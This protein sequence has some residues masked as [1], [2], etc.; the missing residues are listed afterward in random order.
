VTTPKNIAASVRQKLLN[1][2]KKDRRPFNE[3]L[4]YY[5]MERFLYR[6]SQSE[7]AKRFILKGGLMLR[8]W[9][10]PEI[11]P[12]MDI[13]MLAKTSNDAGKLKAQVE[14]MLSVDVEPD[15][16]IFSQESIQT[17]L[18]AE[19]ANYQ[20]VRIRFRGNLGSARINVQLDIGFSDVV[21][22]PPIE[23][24]V[25]TMLDFAAPVLL[26]YCRESS[27]AE[28]FEAMVK[29]GIVNSR[30]KDFYDIWLLS[31]Q[32]DFNGSVLSRA[33]EL[34]FENRRTDL[35]ENIEAFQDAFISE[36][37]I[38]WTAFCRRLEQEHL[39]T[40]FSEVVLQIKRF[41]EPVADAVRADNLFDMNWVAADGW[42][43]S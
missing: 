2:S 14:E 31:R 9:N 28:K 13:D 6:L 27:I 25:P 24:A 8:V 39:P 17:E 19:D 41:L 26:C 20:G 32:F 21:Y 23:S 29:L 43:H 5:A 33:V 38:Q 16:L 36:K 1:R 37:Q 7:Y 34:T 10:S 3:L 22:P 30:M 18:I 42:K 40:L 12:T 35:P 11:R 15:G 4:Q